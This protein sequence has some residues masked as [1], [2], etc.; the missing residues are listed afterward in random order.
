M[1]KYKEITPAQ[2]VEDRLPP[3]PA[4]RRSAQRD[5]W[6]EQEEIVEIRDGPA[7]SEFLRLTTL[8]LRPADARAFCISTTAN[9]GR[10]TA[11]MRN[12]ASGL[13]LDL[14]GFKQTTTP[15]GAER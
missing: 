2:R 5:R 11:Y 6:C 10:P 4:L 12:T 15:S 8:V 9:A 1:A 13:H 3:M 14:A 7:S